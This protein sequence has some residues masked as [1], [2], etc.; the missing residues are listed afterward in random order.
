MVLE[1]LSGLYSVMEFIVRKFYPFSYELIQREIVSQSLLY[2]WDF[3]LFHIKEQKIC[4][5][6]INSVIHKCEN[7]RYTFYA[8]MLA[9]QVELWFSA[10]MGLQIVNY[11]IL[12]MLC[13]HSRSEHFH[14]LALTQSKTLW[15]H[16][17]PGHFYAKDWPSLVARREEAS[18]WDGVL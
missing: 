3:K 10:W 4:H 18:V 11:P 5:Q 7:D 16:R 15:E 14:G 2:I 6:F 17:Q 13:G 1:D 12:T 8:T 9:G